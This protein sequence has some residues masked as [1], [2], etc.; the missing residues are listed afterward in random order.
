MAPV[1]SLIGLERVWHAVGT[2]YSD[3]GATAIDD[4]QYHVPAIERLVVE[5]RSIEP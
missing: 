4:G 2:T 1:I 5:A 3:L